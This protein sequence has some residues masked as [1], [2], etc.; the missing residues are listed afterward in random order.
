MMIS[1]TASASSSSETCRLTVMCVRLSVGRK[2]GRSLSAAD[3]GACN[4]PN[5]GTS[6]GPCGGCARL[7][8]AHTPGS[9]PIRVP[10]SCR[11][12]LAKMHVRSWLRNLFQ[13][14]LD[15]DPDK[16]DSVD[17]GVA[18]VVVCDQYL[19]RRQRS[20]QGRR[21]DSVDV[22]MADGTVIGRHDL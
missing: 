21:A 1:G 13:D 17:V 20:E 3:G 10:Q 14:G 4:T 15:P 16:V 5:S 9:R 6:P 19:S 8:V 11:H 18:H 2:L 12:G 22:F 7:C